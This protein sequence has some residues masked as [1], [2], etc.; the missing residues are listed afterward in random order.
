MG[1]DYCTRKRGSQCYCE[2][3]CQ[4]VDMG[5]GEYN[6]PDNLYECPYMQAAYA[7]EEE[8]SEE[9]SEWDSSKKHTGK[10][11]YTNIHKKNNTDTQKDSDYQTEDYGGSGSSISTFICIDSLFS[12]KAVVC[13]VGTFFYY[14]WKQY[15][16]VHG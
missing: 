9:E 16:L 10:K 11:S 2:Y 15:R 3:M 1:C 6:C 5:R 12:V 14:Y 7:M 4:Y 13:L 8:E